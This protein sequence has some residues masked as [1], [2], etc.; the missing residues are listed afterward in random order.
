IAVLLL[1]ER[2]TGATTL[3]VALLLVAVTG[4]AAQE[5]RAEA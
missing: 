1:G 2:L 3:G 4:L 5:R